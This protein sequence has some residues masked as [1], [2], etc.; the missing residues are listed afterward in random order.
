MAPPRGLA[1]HELSGG[2][3]RDAPDSDSNGRRKVERKNQKKQGGRRGL[4]ATQA[5]RRPGTAPA[6]G[7]RAGL[8]RAGARLRCI[9][10]IPRASVRGTEL[11]LCRGVRRGGHIDE[12]HVDLR[13]PNGGSDMGKAGL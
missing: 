6:P 11:S 10:S 12:W 1:R 2:S 13:K 3:I 7:L 9:P 8:T 5:P 4:T